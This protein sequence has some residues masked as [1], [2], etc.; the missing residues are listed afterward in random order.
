MRG[1]SAP[2]V[3]GWTLLSIV[4]PGAAHLRAGQKRL[5]LILL[6]IYVALLLGAGVMYLSLGK[7][8]LAGMATNATWMSVLIALCAVGALAWAALVI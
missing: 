2:S 3:I 4:V 5:G 6:G 1:W 7:D 8:Q